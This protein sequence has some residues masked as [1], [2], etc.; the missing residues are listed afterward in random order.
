V[1]RVYDLLGAKKEFAPTIGEGPHKDTQELQVAVLRWFNR[2]LKGVDPV[3]D[4]PAIPMFEPEKLR[5]FE[6]GKEPADLINGRVHEVFVPMAPKPEVPKTKEQWEKQRDA[7]MVGLK[8]KC[9]RAWGDEGEVRVQLSS[10]HGEAKGKEAA[11]VELM[12]SGDVSK[13]ERVS[14]DAAIV[15]DFT[16]RII[17]STDEKVR[18]HLLRR[19]ALL[20]RTLDST[21][22]WDVRAAI[23]GAREVAESRHRPLRVTADGPM[24]GVALYASLFEPGV[25]ELS[26]SNLPASHV[27]GPH[28]LNVLRVLDIPQ[29]VAMAA[30]RSHVVLESVNPTDWS[31][32]AET[33]KS[34]G[35]ANHLEIRPTH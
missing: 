22:V 20:G 16:P 26:L 2:K 6:P 3:I 15:I 8:E 9:F 29:S 17:R 34:L 24:A 11:P 18:R 4:K 5:V 7:W 30:E 13:E 32:A 25:S 31:Y 12:V 1:R 33:A 27:N 35:W 28:F 23:R 19:F 10:R 21:Q 14:R